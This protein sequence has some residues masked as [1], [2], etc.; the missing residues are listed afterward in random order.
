LITGIRP[1]N[2]AGSFSRPGVGRNHHVAK[3]LN[4][5]A[6]RVEL[7][8]SSLGLGS[9]LP[10]A[11]TTTPTLLILAECLDIYVDSGGA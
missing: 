2:S 11:S 1:L 8:P 3:S 9:P 10:G 4:L 5:I 7:R 6:R